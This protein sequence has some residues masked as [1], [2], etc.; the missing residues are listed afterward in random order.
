MSRPILI[1]REDPWYVAEDVATSV[2]SEGETMEEAMANLKEALE[3]YYDG[4]VIEPVP[5]RF[6]LTSMEVNA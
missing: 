6:F 4:S 5:E 1:I 3:L 2:T